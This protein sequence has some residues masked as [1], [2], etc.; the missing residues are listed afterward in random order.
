MEAGA[1]ELEA[2]ATRAHPRAFLR[3]GLAAEKMAHL[4][5]VSPNRIFSRRHGQ[6]WWYG[7]YLQQEIRTFVVVWP[8]SSDYIGDTATEIQSE[9]TVRRYAFFLR[10]MRCQ[11]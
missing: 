5:T 4:Q 1:V 11:T 3:L 6:S 10:R 9:D 7:L 8:V 2:A